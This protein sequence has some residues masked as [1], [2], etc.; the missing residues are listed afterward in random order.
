MSIPARAALKACLS[1]H[2][3]FIVF[4]MV[5]ICLFD[6]MVRWSLAMFSGCDQQCLASLLCL[7]V[8]VNGHSCRKCH[9]VS[10]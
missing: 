6:H 2:I 10:D 1:C 3:F 5:L 8:A 7:A 9:S 4:L